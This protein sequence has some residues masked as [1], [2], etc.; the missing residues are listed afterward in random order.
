M[1]ALFDRI[2]RSPESSQI[3]MHGKNMTE[4]PL[5]SSNQQIFRVE[6]FLHVPIGGRVV[7]IGWRFID[8]FFLS[9]VG[10]AVSLL[11]ATIF[12]TYVDEP[13]KRVSKRVA[14]SPPFA[15]VASPSTLR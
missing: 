11:V 2:R 15:R 10:L 12:W 14:L 3:D 1:K 13:A 9:P 7:N 8:E 6:A 4:P 5:N